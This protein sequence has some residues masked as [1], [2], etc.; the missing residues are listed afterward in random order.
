MNGPLALTNDRSELLVGQALDYPDGEESSFDSTLLR[1][2]G[3]GR[4]AVLL[5]AQ[6]GDLMKWRAY[7]VASGLPVSK[8]LTE[9]PLPTFKVKHLVVAQSPLLDSRNDENLC[10]LGAGV[11]V[12]AVDVGHEH[13]DGVRQI[14]P[15]AFG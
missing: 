15:S 4:V 9:V 12:M 13:R 5:T 6:G 10:T 2:S 14:G 7:D 1:L 8:M 3:D 11:L